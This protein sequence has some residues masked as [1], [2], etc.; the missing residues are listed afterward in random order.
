MRE[1]S[2]YVDALRADQLP[3]DQ[4]FLFGSYAHG[5]QHRW[6]DVDLCIVSSKFRTPWEALQYLWKKVPDTSLTIEPV[7]FGTRDFQEGSTLIN[8]I[9]RTGVRI[10]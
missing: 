6:S 3:I 9:K 7:G 4:V 10:V 2:A 1:V 5:T 8:E